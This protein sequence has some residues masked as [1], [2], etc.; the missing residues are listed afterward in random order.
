M[1]LIDHHRKPQ[2]GE[3]RP[4][5]GPRGSGRKVA[6]AD[7]VLRVTG[8]FK[9]TQ[10]DA[11]ATGALTLHLMKDRHGRVD[12]INDR[13]QC[14]SFLIDHAGGRVAIARGTAPGE[15]AE[16][17]AESIL[18]ERVL[19]AI[20]AEPGISGRQLA[21]ATGLGHGIVAGVAASLEA[22]GLVVVD[23]TGKSHRHYPA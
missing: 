6:D 19:A 11:P 13:N 7:L 12:S 21:A 16:D 20:E 9:R 22:G 5:T 10:R 15:P 4:P 3:D 8:Q 14:G 23:R 1:L 2:G 18:A 17:L